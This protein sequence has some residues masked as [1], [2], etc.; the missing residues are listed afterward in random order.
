MRSL[1]SLLLGTVLA[2]APPPFTVTEIPQPFGL[3]LGD[4]YFTEQGSAVGCLER[5][6]D[7]W[8]PFIW[9]RHRG[10]RLIDGGFVGPRYTCG[11]LGASAAGEVAGRLAGPDPTTWPYSR[12]FVWSDEQGLQLFEDPPFHPAPMFNRA[13]QLMYVDEELGFGVWTAAEGFTAIDLG[14]W[15]L[16]MAE[17]NDAGYVWGELVLET[18][19]F[20]WPTRWF[21][22]SRED[23]LRI[24]AGDTPGFTSYPYVRRLS[25]D[26]WATGTMSHPT[27]QYLDRGYVSGPD[28]TFESFALDDYIIVISAIGRDGLVAGYGFSE[29]HGQVPFVFEPGFGVEILGFGEPPSNYESSLDGAFSVNADNAVVGRA[30]AG[31]G[32]TQAF[33]WRRGKGIERVGRGASGVYLE[34]RINDAGWVASAGYGPRGRL[35][36][37]VWSRATGVVGHVEIDGEYGWNSTIGHVNAEGMATGWYQPPWWVAPRQ[38]FIFVPR[39]GTF[40]PR[41]WLP[42]LHPDSIFPW[43]L[44]DAGEVFLVGDDLQDARRRYFVLRPDF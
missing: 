13:G 24:V 4:V 12:T 42:P 30:N 9:D 22:W 5:G 6:E 16:A 37:L 10:T 36:P 44:T 27:D 1:L 23:G 31:G 35:R 14:E 19:T 41:D 2:Q 26:G 43:A 25:D 29:E 34:P 17:Q 39:R 40:D 7:D 11:V 32:F 18:D 38:P 21:V 28:G 3:A 33:V 8:L 20:P 15:R